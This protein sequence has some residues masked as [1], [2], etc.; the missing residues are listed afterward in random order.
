[1]G[2]TNCKSKKHQNVRSINVQSCALTSNIAKSSTQFDMKFHE[3]KEV[4]KKYAT[5]DESER[6]HYICKQF[7]HV[8]EQHK[9]SMVVTN[10]RTGKT[11]VINDPQCIKLTICIATTGEKI[12]LKHDRESTMWT[13][14]KINICLKATVEKEH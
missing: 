9:C 6:L 14:R 3:L 12:Y 5:V 8:W 1:M 7:L 2:C 13:N 11:T 4:L 10:A